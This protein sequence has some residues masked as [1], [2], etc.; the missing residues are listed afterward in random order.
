MWGACRILVPRRGI[1][2]GPCEWKESQPLWTTKELPAS[3]LYTKTSLK[4]IK[5]PS[6]WPRN[7]ERIVNISK[8]LRTQTKATY[9]F[10]FLGFLSIRKNKRSSL[11]KDAGDG[12]CHT[13]LWEFQLTKYSTFENMPQSLGC[14]SFWT[15]RFN[16]RCLWKGNIITGVFFLELFTIV[17]GSLGGLEA[18]GVLRASTGL[19]VV[20]IS[21]HQRNIF[22]VC[23]LVLPY[24]LSVMP[25]VRTIY[26]KGLCLLLIRSELEPGFVSGFFYLSTG[27]GAW[28]CRCSDGKWHAC[29]GIPG[30]LSISQFLFSIPLLL[31]SH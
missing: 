1:E 10:Y 26:F 6:Q 4:S 28:L 9:H 30:F 22:I 27:L 5:W 31:F 3:P 20:V 14:A 29:L 12:H 19:G 7:Q 15:Q 24:C 11:E 16:S 13:L 8:K 2:S 18:A 23:Q 25:V 17:G 21:I